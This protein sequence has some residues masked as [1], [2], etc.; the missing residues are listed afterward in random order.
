MKKNKIPK[1][2]NP[3]A[4]LKGK[5]ISLLDFAHQ[6]NISFEAVAQKESIWHPSRSAHIISDGKVIGTIGEISPR[7][8]AKFGV[9]RRIVCALFS[10]QDLSSSYASIVLSQP[11]PKFPYAVRDISL[12]FRKKVTVGEIERL[13]IEAGA[14]LLKHIE[15]FDIYEQGEE[16]S[17]AFHLSFGAEDRTLSS[18]EMDSTFDRIVAV[19]NERFEARLR[20]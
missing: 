11:L 2:D 4:L 7:I 10:A 5:V 1:N 12:T 13:I 8:L 19:A 15:L 6:K 17:L 18:D 16:K 14:P 3:F 9:K 20:L